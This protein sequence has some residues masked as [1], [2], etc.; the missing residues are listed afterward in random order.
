ML[1]VPNQ[2]IKKHNEGWVLLQKMNYNYNYSY[3]FCLISII[4]K[5]ICQLKFKLQL[6]FSIT[7]TT[8][9]WGTIPPLYS[10]I[11][12]PPPPGPGDEGKSDT[13]IMLNLE[14]Y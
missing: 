3:I 7:I 9:I 8:T 4:I 13:E 10:L 6:R 5:I 1:K 14:S 2:R 11:Q 12:R